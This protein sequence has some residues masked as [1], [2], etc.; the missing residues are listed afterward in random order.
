MKSIKTKYLTVI[1][2]L[3]LTTC[4]SGGIASYMI[5]KKQMVATANTELEELATQGA[6]IMST[7]I[8]GQW[9]ALEYL[10][11]VDIISDPSVSLKD[12]TSFL[13]EVVDAS[14][15]SKIV[16]ADSNGN[17]LAPYGLSLVNISTR[18]YFKR[19]M[20]GER[21]I[22]DPIENASTPGQYI[23]TISVPV[24]WN[25]KVVGILFEYFDTERISDITNKIQFGDTGTTYAVNAETIAVAN[26]NLDLVK[27]KESILE[28]A[29]KDPSYQSFA[30]LT[31]KIVT[32]EIGHGS[33]SYLGTEKYA[34]FSP[35]NNTDWF[36]SVTIQK[37]ELLSGLS[38]M[39]SG[40]M[41]EMLFMMVIAFIITLLVTNSLVKPIK[42]LSNT[43]DTLATG[44]FTNEISNLLMKRKDELG[45][46]AT[47][48]H[49]MKT[50][51]SNTLSIVMEE[52][53]SV[54]KNA[55]TQS[56][57]IQILLNEIEEVSATVEELSAGAEETAA[58]TEEMNASSAEIEESIDSI[59][60]KAEQGALDANNIS[61]RAITLKEN[62]VQSKELAQSLHMEAE[63][64]LKESIEEAKKVNE[65]TKLSDAILQISSQTNL[66]ALNAA[67][68]AAR[69]GEAGKGF[70]VVAEEIRSLAESSKE[71]V[72]NIQK[73]TADVI[74]SVEH[75]TDN[76][77]GMLN[78]INT[79]VSEDYDNFIANGEQYYSDAKYVSDFVTELSATSEELSATMQA[80]IQTIHG[81][82]TAT[83]E[84]AEGTTHI[85]DKVEKVVYNAKK[86]SDYA[87]DTKNTS[88]KLVD[89]ISIFK[90][91]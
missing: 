78:Y 56:E 70:S 43:L 91:K 9:R 30:D 61:E 49:T 65:I 72:E 84:E 82:S 16:Y 86:V 53:H 38:A 59:A 25:G 79:T 6:N 57:S 41:I 80:M 71:L 35:I 83:Q 21:F 32:G 68:E 19:S 77:N 55:G 75:L 63:A 10:T 7:Y 3:V 88:D 52:T 42:I 11:A 47:S 23:N 1:L 44:D 81:I 2:I 74:A 46:L 85:A 27:N 62:A 20:K 33:Y 13:Q 54:S 18:D 31:E 60:K 87:G 5:A 34:G 28:L 24:T 40:I 12:K 69:A 64:A 26:Q 48:L 8:E 36:L 4:L 17:C 29:K 15:A 14:D 89:A 66:L 50:S 39:S 37:D 51:V 22:S 90:V 45:K 76:A 73:V 58:S 67:I